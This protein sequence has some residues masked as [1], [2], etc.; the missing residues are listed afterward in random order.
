MADIA[1]GRQCPACGSLVTLSG[2]FSDKELV[3]PCPHCAL[4]GRDTQLSFDNPRY[5]PEGG[6]T[7]KAVDDG[8]PSPDTVAKY[9]DATGAKGTPPFQKQGV[10]NGP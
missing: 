3:A 6:E 10:T 8:K 5:T 1:L 2:K 4:T 7:P 9:T